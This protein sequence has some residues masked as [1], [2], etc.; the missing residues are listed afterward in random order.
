M[1]TVDTTPFEDAPSRR[2]RDR[3]NDNATCG[4]C[5][6]RV[7]KGHECEQKREAM[8][9]RNCLLASCSKLFKPKVHGQ[10]YCCAEHK[11]QNRNS[12]EY[13]NKLKRVAKE[14]KRTWPAKGFTAEVNTIAPLE[15]TWARAGQQAS[16]YAPVMGEALVE[17]TLRLMA[18]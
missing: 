4:Y 5:R 13:A 9:E 10:G 2:T 11:K 15:R 7:P 3:N 14:E 6:Q 1:I 17:M 8:K 16:T 12:R 18:K